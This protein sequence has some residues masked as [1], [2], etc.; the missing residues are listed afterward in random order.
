MTRA[1]FDETRDNLG[2]ARNIA[3]LIPIND[4]MARIIP[5]VCQMDVSIIRGNQPTAILGTN[6]IF[7]LN[8]NL[9]PREPFIVEA[10]ARSARKPRSTGY[11]SAPAAPDA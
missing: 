4:G 11:R 5:N 9:R 10:R 6:R 3:K 8:N 7:D 2:G 1:F